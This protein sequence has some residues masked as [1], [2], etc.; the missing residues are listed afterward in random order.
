VGKIIGG[1]EGGEE[2]EEVVDNLLDINCA[3]MKH[4]V[5]RIV[6]NPQASAGLSD[7][8]E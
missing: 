8:I 2:E 6:I 1:E 3:S 4:L 5:T 7:D